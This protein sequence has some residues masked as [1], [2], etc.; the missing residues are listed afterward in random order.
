MRPDKEESSTP[1]TRIGFMPTLLFTVML[2]VTTHVLPEHN[3]E[4][5]GMSIQMS[6]SYSIK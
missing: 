5:A 2:I 3:I 4:Q 1:S 6:I